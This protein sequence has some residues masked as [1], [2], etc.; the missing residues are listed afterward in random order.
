MRILVCGGRDFDN[1]KLLRDTLDEHSCFMT[2]KC[3][4]ISGKARGAD[5]LGEKWAEENYLEV[6][7]Y[8]A[9]WAKY[10]SKA[11]PIR[12]QQM[13]DEGKPDLVVA[14]PTPRSKGTWD[15]IRRAEKHG[16][17]TIVVK[18]EPN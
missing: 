13:I 11:G 12:N 9:N 2:N 15:M 5:T 4:I 6:D 10:G 8:P 16:I 14:F 7:P 1:Y 17:R 3:V 18:H